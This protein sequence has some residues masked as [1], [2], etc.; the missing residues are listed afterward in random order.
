MLNEMQNVPSSFDAAINALSLP[1][2]EASVV[3]HLG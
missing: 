3:L 2:R 1:N